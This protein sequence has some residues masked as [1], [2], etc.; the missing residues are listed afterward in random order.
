M[1]KAI[2]LILAAI[3]SLIGL[4]SCVPDDSP[5]PAIPELQKQVKALQADN[6]AAKATISQLSANLTAAKTE[7]AALNAAIKNAPTKDELV[8]A[9]DASTLNQTQKDILQRLSIVEGLQA[10]DHAN[11]TNVSRDVATLKTQGTG[12]VQDIV[13][14]A[15]SAGLVTQTTLSQ[16]QATEDSRYNSLDSRI[17]ILEQ[18][19]GLR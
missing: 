12:K 19:A 10:Q 7:M 14:N 4:V 17:Q 6:T 3:I 9:F 2:C 18:K 13:Q 16:Y 1:Y 11:L 15:A 5:D 8:K